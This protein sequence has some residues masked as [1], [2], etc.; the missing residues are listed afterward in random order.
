MVLAIQ[1]GFVLCSLTCLALIFIGLKKILAQT[2]FTAQ[3]QGRILICS[4]SLTAIWILFISIFALYGFFADF[5]TLP[6]RMFLVLGIPLIAILIVTFNS[7]FKTI[8]LHTP[9]SWLIYIQSFRIVV[10]ILLWMMLIKGI[11]PIQ[12]T[13]EGFNYDILVGLTAPLFAYI[14]YSRN[15][16]STRVLVIW[17]IGGMLLL[18][19]IVTIAILSFPTPLRQFM[20]D[21]PNTAV[22][23]FPYIWLPG[24]LVVIAYS[25]HLFSLRKLYLTK[26]A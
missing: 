6:P 24:I 12:M 25:M 18:G 4:I 11:T 7:G 10:E 20:N 8:L 26:E 13:F 21:P 15:L 2:P 16:W 9:G 5:S 19:N 23:E 14:I 17:N 3:T 1:L 22:A